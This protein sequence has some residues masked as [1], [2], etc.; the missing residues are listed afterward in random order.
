MSAQEFRQAQQLRRRP[1]TLAAAGSRYREVIEARARA[2]AAF[3][4]EWDAIEAAAIRE[5]DRHLPGRAE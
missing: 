5:I 2:L 4:L 1:R 3:H